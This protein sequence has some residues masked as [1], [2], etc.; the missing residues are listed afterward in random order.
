MYIP[1]QDATSLP[2][3]VQGPTYQHGEWSVPQVSV[4]AAR[5]AAGKLH[6]AFTN[7]DPNRG[8]S[9]TTKING[10]NAKS[11]TGRILTA[12]A[13]DA[14]NT[15]DKPEAVKPAPFKGTRKGNELRV[16]LPPKSVVVVAVE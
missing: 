7:A 10:M 11:L 1:F 2:A 9:V 8:A 6:I 12:N 5:D 13:M 14:R 3:E 16:D 15:V 4:S